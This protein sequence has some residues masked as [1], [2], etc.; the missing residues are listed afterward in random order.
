MLIETVFSSY[1]YFIYV[2]LFAPE[3]NRSEKFPFQKSAIFRLQLRG[4][5][6][7]KICGV[8]MHDANGTLYRSGDLRSVLYN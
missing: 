8:L 6:L 2:S 7:R 4:T 5:A 1:F 3:P